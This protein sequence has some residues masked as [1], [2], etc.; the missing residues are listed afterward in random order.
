M[1]AARLFGLD[2]LVLIEPSYADLTN[3][4]YTLALLDTP[5]TEGILLID[6]HDVPIALALSDGEW[7]GAC[8][9]LCR[10]PT[11]AVI[12]KIEELEGG[13]CQ[14]EREAWARAVREHYSTLLQNTVTPALEDVTKSRIAQVEYLVREVWNESP[15]GTRCLD[16]CCGS[17]IG[18]LAL[19][20]AGMHP[21][22]FDN[23]AALISRGLSCGRLRAEDTVCIDATRASR[24]LPHAG[25]GLSLMLGS[26]GPYDAGMWKDIVAEIL[27]LCDDAVITVGTR[28]EGETIRGWVSP[29]GRPWNLWENTRDPIYDRWVCRIGPGV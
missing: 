1:K 22:A 14:A 6:E 21:L 15:P 25:R 18:S 28:E 23:D 16:C 5:S 7:W 20:S 8:S 26:I 12:E 27:T 24:Y 29:T 11:A 4:Y 19:R 3:P 2:D 10:D 13:I 17:G 9:F